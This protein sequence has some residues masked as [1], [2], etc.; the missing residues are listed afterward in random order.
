MHDL[1]RTR[2]HAVHDARVEEIALVRRAL[3]QPLC[4]RIVQHILKDGRRRLECFLHRLRNIFLD[5][6]HIEKP[7]CGVDDIL[8]CDQ[9]FLT[10]KMQK[11][12]DFM[13]YI[14]HDRSSC[15]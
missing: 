14:T 9:P 12:A 2:H 6:Q 1:R 13:L 11:A 15:S 10:G 7:I 3:D 5:V 8:G 4:R